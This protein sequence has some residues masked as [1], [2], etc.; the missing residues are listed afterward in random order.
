MV[1]K[2]SKCFLFGMFLTII[3]FMSFE[4]VNAECSDNTNYA[5]CENADCKWEFNSDRYK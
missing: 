4:I 2:L 5:D 3:M 1:M